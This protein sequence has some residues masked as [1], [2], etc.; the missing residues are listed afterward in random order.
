MNFHTPCCGRPSTDSIS[1]IYNYRSSLLNHCH[2][3]REGSVSLCIIRTAWSSDKPRSSMS[4]PVKV[5]QPTYYEILQLPRSTKPIDSVKLKA[6]YRRALLLHHPDKKYPSFPIT[7]NPVEQTS[8]QAHSVD[9][10]TEA[11]KTLSS[12]IS[13]GDYDKLLE[14]TT[15]P[16]RT[17]LKENHH[18]GVETFDLEE[19][20]YNDKS[21]TW[22]RQCRCGDERAYTLTS[23]DLENESEHGEIY[24]GCKGCSLFIRVLF[25]SASTGSVVDDSS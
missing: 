21:D 9:Q 18:A 7:S 15:K 11:Y 25:D 13:K 3:N 2:C 8:N 23:S 16:L 14:E 1:P 12:A 20:S 4:G 24:A 10:I 5:S 19:L 6:A 22:F 17:G